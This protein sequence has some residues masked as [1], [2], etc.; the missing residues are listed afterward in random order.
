V[1]ELCTRCPIE[2]FFE[3]ERPE[4][5]PSPSAGAASHAASLARA[6]ALARII[7]ATPENWIAMTL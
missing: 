3:R 4:R 7:D 1:E 5:A 2:I 6:G